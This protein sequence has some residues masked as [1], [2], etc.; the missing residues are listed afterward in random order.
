ME[1]LLRIVL[2]ERKLHTKV[3]SKVVNIWLRTRQL[4]AQ[5][6]LNVRAW[7]K[8]MADK[9]YIIVFGQINCKLFNTGNLGRKLFAIN[10]ASIWTD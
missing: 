4:Q 9:K 5:L 1:N 8:A 2:H 3:A 6:K 10:L 7:F